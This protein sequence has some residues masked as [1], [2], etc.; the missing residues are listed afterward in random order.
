MCRRRRRQTR[1]YS[2][3]GTR[4]SVLGT[5]YSVLSSQ[6]SALS[7]QLSEKRK[8]GDPP[9]SIG[10]W[11]LWIRRLTKTGPSSNRLSTE[12]RVLSTSFTNSSFI[13]T[14]ETFAQH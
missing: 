14:R 1:Q 12:Y 10:H 6:L 3:L 13:N 2:V 8:I 11:T 5:Q 4:Y 7:S 9:V